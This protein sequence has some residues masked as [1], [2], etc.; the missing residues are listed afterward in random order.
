MDTEILNGKSVLD[1]DNSENDILP[2]NWPEPPVIIPPSDGVVIVVLSDFVIVISEVVT[3]PSKFCWFIVN[4]ISFGVAVVSNELSNANT[5]ES[6]L[7]DN[8]LA[9][10][11]SVTALIASSIGVPFD[12]FIW[13]VIVSELPSQTNLSLRDNLDVEST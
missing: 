11:D 9:V 2:L 1:S 6:T 10:D 5:C 7:T 12:K 3:A 4:T 8:A 13:P